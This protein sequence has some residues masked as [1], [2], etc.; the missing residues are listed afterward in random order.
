[1]CFQISYL[2]PYFLTF[3]FL[4]VNYDYIY[5]F[6]ILIFIWSKSIFNIIWLSTYNCILILR[7]WLKINIRRSFNDKIKRS[8]RKNIDY[9]I[10][11]REDG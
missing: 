2:L 1:M 9:K 10:K 8:Y 4:C 7:K 5:I 3:Y 11:K 6:H